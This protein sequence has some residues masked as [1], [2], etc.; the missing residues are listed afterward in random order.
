MARRKGFDYTDI[1]NVIHHGISV[2]T[3]TVGNNYPALSSGEQWWCE[4]GLKSKYKI[5]FTFCLILGEGPKR[6]D[7]L[8][9]LYS[10]KKI[11]LKKTYRIGTSAEEVADAKKKLEAY[12]FLAWL[13]PH[14]RLR[15]TKNNTLLLPEE[16]FDIKE[17][18]DSDIEVSGSI[19]ET[20]ESSALFSGKRLD[21]EGKVS[22]KRRKN[23]MQVSG[24]IENKWRKRETDLMFNHEELDVLDKISRVISER[25]KPEDSSDRDKD[26]DDVFGEMIAKELKSFPSHVKF[27]IKHEMNDVLYK[28]HLTELQRQNVPSHHLASFS[29]VPLGIR[30]ESRSIERPESPASQ[31][32]PQIVSALPFSLGQSS[33]VASLTPAP[34]MVTSIPRIGAFS[35]EDVGQSVVE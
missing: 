9:K 20:Q 27:K 10:K 1:L 19:G 7:N 13:E 3:T 34:T 30:A 11:N 14:I 24:F 8:K 5:S 18:D 33:S 2:K 6:F 23:M 35:G 15:S 29:Q 31:A 26:A 12:A 25:K 28:Y 4:S 16:S 32:F 21:K 22:A 17:S